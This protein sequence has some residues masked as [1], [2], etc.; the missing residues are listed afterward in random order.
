MASLTIYA[1][2]ATQQVAESAHL[3][4]TGVEPSSGC[5]H[6]PLHLPGRLALMG[7]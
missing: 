5:W 2:Q 6:M 7:V 1:A 3:Q 4:G